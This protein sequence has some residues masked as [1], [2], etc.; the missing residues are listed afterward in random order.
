[1]LRQPTKLWG[2]D[3]RYVLTDLIVRPPHRVW[4]VAELVADLTSAG[5]DLGDRPSKHVSDV[6]RAEIARGRVRRVGWGR[7]EA[8]HVPGGT[9]RRIRA[10]A[11]LRRRLLVDG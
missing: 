5:F 4:T 9:R 1:M 6:L 7:Y 10:R 11:R 3:L 8:G 2:I